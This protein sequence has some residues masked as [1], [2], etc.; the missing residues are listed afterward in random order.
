MRS[1]IL[2]VLASAVVA[3]AAEA[4]RQPAN[5]GPKEGDGVVCGTLLKTDAEGREI[6]DETTLSPNAVR[7]DEKNIV[8]TLDAEAQRLL[9]TQD[10]LVLDRV[11]VHGELLKAPARIQSVTRIEDAPAR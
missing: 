11:C 9:Q 4:K 5:A 3:L 10:R 7:S 2:L 6:P 1:L 8:Y